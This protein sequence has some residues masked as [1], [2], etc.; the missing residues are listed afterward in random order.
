MDVD[1]L[2][3][4]RRQAPLRSVHVPQVS[5]LLW[6]LFTDYTKY[7]LRRSFHAVRLLPMAT[8]PQATDLP[9]LIYSNHPSWWDPLIYLFLA[10]HFWPARTHYAPMETQALTRYRLFARLGCFAV[11]AGTWQGAA[12]FLRVSQAVLRQPKT[13]LWLTPEGQFRDPRQRP[14][15]FQP[16]LGHLVRR[17]DRCLLLPLA[18]EYP[19]WQER[20]PEVLL[21]FGEAV[22]VKQ[23][24]EHSATAWTALLSHRLGATQTRLADAACR[25]DPQAFTRLLRGRAGVGGTYDLWRAMRAR[26]R[27]EAF[28]Q[29]HGKEIP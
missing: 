15:R 22:V 13:V 26:W 9:L 6:R 24:R 28:Q 18:L 19:F 14:V 1:T 2:T 16:G 4:E 8:L 11:T 25:R 3:T 27:G 29:A 10:R 17:L 7:Y 20:F 12:T 23:A 5:P 21:C